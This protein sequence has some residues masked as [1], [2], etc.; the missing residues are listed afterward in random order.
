MTTIRK[1]AEIA[2]R[3]AIA[4]RTEELF[5]ASGALRSAILQ[6]HEEEG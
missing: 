5:R 6:A 2:A 1:G 3:M 4:A